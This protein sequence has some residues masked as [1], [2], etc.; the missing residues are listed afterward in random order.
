[1]VQNIELCGYKVPT[2]V[3]AYTIPAAVQ[4]RDIIA[5]AQTGQPSSPSFCHYL[6]L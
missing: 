3:Q 2:P 6:I 4:N 5:V 1:M